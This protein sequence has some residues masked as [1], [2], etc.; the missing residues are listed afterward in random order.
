MQ[1]QARD[2]IKEI[3]TNYREIAKPLMA[4]ISRRHRKG[5]LTVNIYNEVRALND[6]IA[7]CFKEDTSDERIAVEL[8]KAEGHIRRLLYDCFK[9]LNVYLHD[10]VERIERICY[11][12]RWLYEDGGAFWEK[13]LQLKKKSIENVEKAKDM[14]S[15]DS[16]E[17]L[18]FYE[19]GY[20]AYREL[21]E[22]FKRNKRLLWISSLSK[23]G[24]FLTKAFLW[25]MITATVAI[26][27]AIIVKH[28]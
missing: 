16:D 9:Q 12:S 18:A 15:V 6:H 11:S 27:A 13:Y 23:V 19:S 21:E 25:L 22:L 26:V 2:R 1:E 4:D 3:L 17:A 24:V 10:R 20:K 7:R 28:M 5:N 8:N 14:E